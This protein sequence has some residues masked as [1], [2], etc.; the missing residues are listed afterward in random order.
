MPA[1]FSFILLACYFRNIITK[2][3]FVLTHIN[4]AKMNRANARQNL[5]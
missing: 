2:V 5:L 4:L 3:D 1:V